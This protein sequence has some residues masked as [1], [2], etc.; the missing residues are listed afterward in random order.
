VELT[1][2]QAVTAAKLEPTVGCP[3]ESRGGRF[4]QYRQDLAQ[5]GAKARNVVD[6]AI[7]H[8]QDCTAQRSSVQREKHFKIK[9][10]W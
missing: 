8:P 3:I 4:C 5:I 9:Q 2:T 6:C 10:L 1:F 7:A